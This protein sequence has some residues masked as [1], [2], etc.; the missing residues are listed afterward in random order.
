MKVSELLKVVDEGWV[1]KSKGFRVR[2]EKMVDSDMVTEYLPSE[3]EPPFDSDVTAW[4]AAW[5]LAQAA[6]PRENL[7]N[8][9][10]C[11]NICVV[12]GQG[13]TIKYYVTNQHEVFNPH[14]VS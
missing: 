6:E 2:F 1:Q 13:N 10:D 7:I 9:G 8:E 4:R 12:D 3:E 14:D 5:K 11:V